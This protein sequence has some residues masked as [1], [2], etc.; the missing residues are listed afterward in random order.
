M[1]MD[2]ILGNA[3]PQSGDDAVKCKGLPD[4][5]KLVMRMKALKAARR[6]WEARWKAIRDFELPYIGEFE[7][8]ADGGV[9]YRC[10]T[11]VHTNAYA[12]YTYCQSRV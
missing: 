11:R 9:E 10:F 8:T 6:D 2:T 4:R 7:D 5:G 1:P 12:G 3:L